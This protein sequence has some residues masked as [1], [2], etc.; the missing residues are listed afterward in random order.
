MFKN[1]K[2]F[3]FKVFFNNCKL[4]F[5][6]AI[7]Y[8]IL[9]NSS[10]VFF[11]FDYYKVNLLGSILELTKDSFYIILTLTIIFY[12]LS[13]NRIAL[14]IGSIFLFITGAVGNY[15]FYFFQIMP[16][17]SM[18]RTIFENEVSETYASVSIYLILWVSISIILCVVILLKQINQNPGKK[19]YIIHVICLSLF[20]LNIVKPQYKVLMSYFPI[21]YLHSTYSYISSKYQHHQK[22]DISQKYKFSCNTDE[23]IL[24]VLVIGESA[25]YDHFG[26]NGY[27][28]NTTPHLSKIDNLFSFKAESA[29]NLTYLS[30]PSMLTMATRQNIDDAVNQTTFLSVFRK[31]GFQT[32]W[33]GTQTIMKYLKGYNAET[34][35]DEAQIVMIPGG[36]VLYPLNAH[37]EV[38]IP[39]LEQI[40]QQNHAKQII[41][42]HTSGSHWNYAARYP[43]H[44]NEFTPSLENKTTR[45]DQPNCDHTEL[46]NSY[47]NSILYTDFVLTQIIDKLKNKNAFL[48]YASDH[49]ESLGENGIYAHGSHMNTE[50]LTIPFILW[51]SDMFIERNK[52]V[53][54]NVKALQQ[55]QLSHDYIF[56]T[57][58]GCSG[59]ESS[60]IDQKLNICYTH[61]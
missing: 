2:Q 41:V 22:T 39:Y 60:V 27:E 26:I 13:I 38:L 49:G 20:I 54:E 35:Y 46:I 29:A 51:F 36:S 19:K 34:M 61:K 24:G 16:T 12:G 48:I 55:N 18:I 56:H 6:L 32:S 28:R 53:I 10:L 44:Y 50:Q 17:T 23:E 5:F 9:F 25:R 1:K 8:H 33:I 4:P 57:I 30:V 3:S 42:I 14:S 11:K 43:K 59:V 52:S 7:S 47:D 58:L 15:V 21:S 31:L 45:I 37:D 40:L